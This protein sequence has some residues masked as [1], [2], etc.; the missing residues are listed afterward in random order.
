MW[1]SLPDF[2]RL[3]LNQ[4]AARLPEMPIELW[5]SILT[6]VDSDSPC[7]QVT[8]KCSVKKEWAALCADGTVYDLANQ[9]LGWYG[10]YN[11]WQDLM[12]RFLQ[13]T[14]RGRVWHAR[15]GN[16]MDAK[17][18]FQHV[19][20]DRREIVDL[21][22]RKENYFYD[23]IN[24]SSSRARI[25]DSYRLMA[26]TDNQLGV[27]LAI[28][29]RNGANQP[30]MPYA[31]A[32]C[33]FA[34]AI[35]GSL[36]SDVP[37]SLRAGPITDTV[38]AQTRADPIPA[39]IH[40]YHEIA[41]AAVKQNGWALK[42]V[43][44]SRRDFGELAR[45]AV[46]GFP[47]ALQ[48]VPGSNYYRRRMP[49]LPP[50]A[51]FAELVGLA[52]RSDKGIASYRSFQEVPA[53]STDYITLLLAREAIFE[54]PNPPNVADTSEG[55]W[56]IDGQNDGVVRLSL[57]DWAPKTKFAEHTESAARITEIINTTPMD[58]SAEGCSAHNA[59]A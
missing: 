44:P 39:A 56:D 47:M 24:P 40:G 4:N 38:F 58:A 22:A 9:K 46:Q 25:A 48:F 33:K 3:R 14:H 57:P 26:D 7:A 10:E 23:A 2:R 30:P 42:Y 31:S 50:R 34:V 43:H 55:W 28:H 8:E 1:S 29:T 53:N 27:L 12:E 17:R 52:M 37:G 11:S 13:G 5:L 6:A 21:L 16:D 19:C 18:W 20:R 36:L 45:I 51:D 59:S 35:D 54:Y 49:A 15:Q 32:L 41:K